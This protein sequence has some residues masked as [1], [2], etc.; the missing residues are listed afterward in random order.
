[1]GTLTYSTVYS[2]TSCCVC[3]IKFAVPKDWERE[4]LNDHKSW[5]CPNGHSQYYSGKSD[6]EKAQERA[7]RLADELARAN[8]RALRE[9][10]AKEAA[11]RSAVA[12]KGHATRARKKAA[13][14]VCPVEGCGKTYVH[15]A[16]HVATK[17]PDF[18][19]E[20][21]PCPTTAT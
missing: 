18:H 12:Y 9:R 8:T 15:L 11:E 14:G 4:R 5:F 6:A 21:M 2:L 10:E 19:P 13:A 7:D 17:H 3:G 16:R 20:E 1:M